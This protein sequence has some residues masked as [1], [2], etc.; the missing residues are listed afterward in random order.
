VKDFDVL[1]ELFIVGCAI[2]RYGHHISSLILT[3]L[4]VSIGSLLSYFRV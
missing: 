4:K 1:A 3:A 2:V